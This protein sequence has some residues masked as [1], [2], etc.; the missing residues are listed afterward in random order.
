MRETSVTPVT[1]SAG[2]KK[3]ED[4]LK[5]RVFTTTYA[6][7]QKDSQQEHWRKIQ[8]QVQETKGDECYTN[9]YGMDITRDKLMSIVKKW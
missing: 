1:K 2:L 9:F 3:E 7:L 6:D 5:G 8:L 4:N